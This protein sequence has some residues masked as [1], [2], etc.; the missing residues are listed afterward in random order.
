MAEARWKYVAPAGLSRLAPGTPLRVLD[1]CVGL[2]YNSACLMDS[3]AAAELPLHWRGLENDPRPLDLALADPSFRACWSPRTLRRLEAL[4]RSGGWRE[5][6]SDGALLWGDARREVQRL[7]CDDASPD[8]AQG[9]DLILLDPFS[10]RRCPQLWS[11]EFLGRLARLLRPGGRLLTYSRAAA[12][13]AVLR[14]AGLQLHSLRPAPG[15]RA[16]WSGGTMAVKPAGGAGATLPEPPTS[17]DHWSPLSPMEEEHLR[18]RAAIP[19][20]DPEGTGTAA[21]LIRRRQQDQ[22]R[23]ALESTGAWQRR[24]PRERWGG[25]KD[26]T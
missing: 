15:Q 6:G 21:E 12:V 25:N 24:W 7:G 2:G 3:P 17:T 11:A 19:Y 4:R 22:A 20:R 14:D 16:D 1:V 23:S 5:G 9:F 26:P 18:C 10:P 8:T 13:R